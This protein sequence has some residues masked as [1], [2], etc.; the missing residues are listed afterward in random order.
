MG[1]EYTSAQRN[2][3]YKWKENTNNKA[4][5][6]EHS[7]NCMRRKYHWDKITKIFFNILIEEN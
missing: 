7:K 2:A 3:I 5:A 6:N 4:K 1:R